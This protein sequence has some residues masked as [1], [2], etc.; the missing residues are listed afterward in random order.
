M[1]VDDIKITSWMDDMTLGFCAQQFLPFYTGV[2]WHNAK[3]YR[4]SYRDPTL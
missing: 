2:W 4:L 1:E 3:P